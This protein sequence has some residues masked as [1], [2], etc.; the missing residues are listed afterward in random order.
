MA[1]E[2]IDTAAVHEQEDDLDGLDSL[3][4]ALF[5]QSTDA[6]LA[7]DRDG[8]IRFWNP[9]A[10]RIFGFA[11][12]EAIG[13]PLDLIIPEALRARHG[14]GYV[15]TM[16]TGTTRYGAGDLLSVPAMTRDGRRISVEFSIVLLRDRN[17][18]PSGTAAIL[19]DAT[20]RFS[21]LKALRQAAAAAR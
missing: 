9:G 12:A 1:D 2:T 19:R 21:E 3:A 6:I 16:A 14:A 5:N 20:A 7:A 18:A 17:G 4:E 8:I 11:A 13:Q 15:Q 10:E